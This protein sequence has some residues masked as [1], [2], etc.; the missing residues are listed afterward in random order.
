MKSRRSQKVLLKKVKN[1]K[2]KNQQPQKARIHAQKGQ[3]LETT[4]WLVV[5]VQTLSLLVRWDDKS[6]IQC[7]TRGYTIKTKIKS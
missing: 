1:A 4:C 3:L 5:V 6:D 7:R 2:K